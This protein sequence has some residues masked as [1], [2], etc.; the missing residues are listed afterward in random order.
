MVIDNITI[1]VLVFYLVLDFTVL[2]LA[3]YNKRG[4]NENMKARIRKAVPSLRI[5][6]WILGGLVVIC[7]VLSRLSGVK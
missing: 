3:V 7:L 6:H 2:F 4:N 1:T 5:I